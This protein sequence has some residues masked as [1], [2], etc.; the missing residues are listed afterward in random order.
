MSKDPQILL[1]HILES[2]EILQSY[3][4]GVDEEQFLHNFKD[5]DAVERGSFN[6]SVKFLQRVATA[7]DAEL[8]I[9]IS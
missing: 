1:Q 5:Q 2:V 6:P 3:L 4:T 9:S 7:L 8:H